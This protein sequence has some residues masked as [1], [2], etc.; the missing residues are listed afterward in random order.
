[1]A[2]L[3]SCPAKCLITCLSAKMEPLRQ[4]FCTAAK[5]TLEI[6]TLAYPCRSV[7]LSLLAKNV[8]KDCKIVFLL[9]TRI[10]SHLSIEW[11]IWPVHRAA[12][13]SGQCIMVQWAISDKNISYNGHIRH[14]ILLSCTRGC[15]S[16][17]KF[18]T[19]HTLVI[20]WRSPSNHIYTGARLF[21]TRNHSIVSS[22]P[23]YL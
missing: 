5:F 19:I 7:T 3:L 15:A 9:C 13:H 10:T 22:V 17:W 16:S 4:E 6:R 1:M 12:L 14:C 23:W 20:S 11:I 18:Y 2:S 21:W 8:R